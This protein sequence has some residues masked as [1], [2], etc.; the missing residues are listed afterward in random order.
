VSYRAL[1]A[2]AW[3]CQ[4]I[5]ELRAFGTLGNVGG[6]SEGQV[7]F[8]DEIAQTLD[9]NKAQQYFYHSLAHFHS[10]VHSEYI[11]LFCK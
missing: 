10:T 4:Q 6:G 3:H 8:L 9:L 5:V 11:K 7:G 1:P 2:P